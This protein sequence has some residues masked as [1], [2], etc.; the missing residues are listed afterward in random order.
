[1]CGSSPEHPVISPPVTLRIGVADFID[2]GVAA[3]TEKADCPTSNNIIIAL[4]K[5]LLNRLCSINFFIMFSF[6]ALVD[7]MF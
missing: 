1:M 7:I 4:G 6:Y 3:S 5:V 2:A